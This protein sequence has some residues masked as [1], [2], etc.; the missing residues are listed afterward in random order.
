MNDCARRVK[1]YMFSLR[2]SFVCWHDIYR[3]HC[4]LRNRPDRQKEEH[5]YHKYTNRQSAA[6]QSVFC[7]G[8]RFNKPIRDPQATALRALA[9]LLFCA[10]QKERQ[11]S[12]EVCTR[13]P[14]RRSPHTRDLKDMAYYGYRCSFSST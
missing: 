14:Q 11:E 9:P 3:C 7:F 4:F 5:L 8:H 2:M 6:V 13:V 12:N 1:L 10:E